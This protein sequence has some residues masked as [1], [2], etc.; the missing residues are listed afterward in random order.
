M[1]ASPKMPKKNLQSHRSHMPSAGTVYIILLYLLEKVYYLFIN[2]IW[3]FC[4]ILR[5]FTVFG[6]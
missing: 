1:H 6:V 2:Q 4:L 3:I 5:K